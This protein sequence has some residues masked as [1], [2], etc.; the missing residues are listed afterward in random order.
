MVGNSTLYLVLAL[1]T[2]LPCQ[3]S[4]NQVST[5]MSSTYPYPGTS[6]MRGSRLMVDA[7]STMV[8]MV[9]AVSAIVV[10]DTLLDFTRSFHSNNN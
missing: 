6:N 9:D 4:R 8:S 10:P 1:P 5:R 3:N 2:M 7:V